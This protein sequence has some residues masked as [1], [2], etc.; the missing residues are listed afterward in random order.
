MPKRWKKVRK[1]EL[2]REDEIIGSSV[3]T[4]EGDGKSFGAERGCQKITV[5]F[6]GVIPVD[7]KL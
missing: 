4:E 3:L 7:D 5:S 2:G 6:K 1:R